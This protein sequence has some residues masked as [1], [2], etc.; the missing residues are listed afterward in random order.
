[1]TQ[2]NAWACMPAGLPA[3][4]S[5]ASLE[6]NLTLPAVVQISVKACGLT[7]GAAT[8]TPMDKANHTSIQRTMERASRRDWREGMAPDY[9]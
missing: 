7:T 3:P 1:M 6:T 9:E 5:A 4:S 8:A 2:S